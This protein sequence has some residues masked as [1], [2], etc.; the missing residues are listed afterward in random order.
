MVRYEVQRLPGAPKQRGVVKHGTELAELLNKLNLHNNV[1]VK[2]NGRTLGDDFDIGYKLQG[3]DLV[4]IYD[5]PQGGGLIKTLLNP[6]EHLNPIRFTKK[7]MEGLRGKQGSPS[8]STGESSNNDTTQQTNRARLYKGR[9]NIY[10]A[11]RAYPDLIQESLFEYQNNRKMVTEWMEVGFGYYDISSVRYSESSLTALAGASYEIIQPGT[12]IAEMPQGYSFDDVD[13]QEIPALNKVTTEIKQQATTDNLLEGYFSGGQFYARILKQ[14]AFDSFFDSSKPLSVTVTVNVTY[15]T[16]SG[17]VTKNV[18]IDA[19]L[20]K[21]TLTDDGQPINPEQYYNFWFD[22]LSGSDL[23]SLPENTTVNSTLF[24]IT[25][26]SGAVVGPFFAAVSSEQLWLHLYGNQG[27]HYDGPV[28]IIWYQVDESNDMIPG[29][30]GSMDVNVRNNGKDQDYVYY[31]YKITPTAGYG[32]YAFTVQRTNNGGSSS[33]VYIS[34][35]HAVNIRRNVVYPDDTLVRVTVRE[36]ETPTAA[37]DRKY[38]CLAQRRVISWT[39]A[40]GVDYTLRPSRSFADAVLHE[41]VMVGKQDLSGL[42]VASLYAIYESLPNPLLG[43]FD[44]TFSDEKLSLGERIQTICNVARVQF[45]WIGD[46]ITFWRDEKAP[47]PD[48]VFSRS[49][50]FWDEYKLS[51]RMSLPGGYDGVTVDYVDPV[52]NKKTYIYL[53]IDSGG[54]RE[55]EDA[56]INASQISLEGCRNRTQAVDR[57]WLEAQRILYSRLSMTVKVLETE[58]VVRGA[59]VQCPDMYDNKQQNG[60]L[61]GRNG[62]IF[63]TSERIDFS[64]GDMWVVMTDS[65]GNFRGRWRAY[66]VTGNAKAFQSAADAFDLNIYNGSDCQVASRYFIATDSELNSSI[67]RVET[68][69]PNGD[70]TQ[71][72]TLSEYSDAIYP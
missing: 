72:L 54:I 25:E 44:Y 70:Y 64:V 49:N 38:N 51:W 4:S 41:W 29:T 32:R 6:L 11:V 48:A 42:D 22:S 69:K 71:T 9:P 27:G 60:Y 68:A 8:I 67:W 58:Q 13:G 10:G 65:L 55:V 59:V 47:Y 56:T 37:K 30:Q 19:S 33:V 2:L 12:V 34:G 23:E 45:N 17:A 40:G 20:F 1:I 7:V 3:G 31:T 16:A 28:H 26:Y 21:S 24:T 50:M 35:A 52:T 53:Q 43:Y 61:T 36:T 14:N 62:D 15:N 18:S 39:P 57:A 46:I 5:Q 66:P 63:T